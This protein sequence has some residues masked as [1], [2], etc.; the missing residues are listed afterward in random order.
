MFGSPVRT[1]QAKSVDQF[2]VVIAN[3]IKNFLDQSLPTFLIAFYTLIT[4]NGGVLK[5]KQKGVY[6][7]NLGKISSRQL[8]FYYNMEQTQIKRIKSRILLWMKQMMKKRKSCWNLMMLL[9]LIIEMK[10]MLQSLVCVEV[11]PAL[12]YKCMPLLRKIKSSDL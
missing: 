10:I 7:D 5:W 9:R 6:R 11:L 2:T 3:L 12:L 8:R 1:D 4:F